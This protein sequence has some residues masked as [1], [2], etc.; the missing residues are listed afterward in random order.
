MQGHLRPPAQTFPS[1]VTLRVTCA[2]QNP[3]GALLRQYYARCAVDGTGNDG[4]SALDIH[5]ALL[6]IRSKGFC[7]ITS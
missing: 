7:A 6:C 4:T 2:H 1:T 3:A 5:F